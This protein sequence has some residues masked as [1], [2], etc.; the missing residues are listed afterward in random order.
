MKNKITTLIL[1]TII[2]FLSLPAADSCPYC[3]KERT[4]SPSLSR[5]NTSSPRRVPSQDSQTTQYAPEHEEAFELQREGSE[6][7]E[8]AGETLHRNP[9]SIP[10][11]ANPIQPQSGGKTVKEVKALVALMERS[12]FTNGS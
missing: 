5:S 4:N 9:S 1:I 10:T 7:A 11:G 12:N 6:S 8:K 3:C 2:S